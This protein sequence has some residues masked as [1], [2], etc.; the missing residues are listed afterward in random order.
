LRDAER[1]LRDL[2]EIQFVDLTVEDIVRHDLVR[3]VIEAYRN[4]SSF[5]SA[6]SSNSLNEY[7]E[8]YREK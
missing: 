8:R 3:S 4:D 7:A 5:P 2:D 6:E 1:R